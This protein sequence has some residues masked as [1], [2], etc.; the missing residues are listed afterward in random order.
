MSKEN[1]LKYIKEFSKITVAGVCE[2]LHID[3]SNL[4]AGRASQ[5]S[6]EAVR[7]TIKHKL[8]ELEN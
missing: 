8:D 1:D 5:K 2:E 3:K 7:K 4:W 6:T